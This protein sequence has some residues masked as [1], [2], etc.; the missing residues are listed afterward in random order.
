MSTIKRSF[1]LKDEDLDFISE[2]LR[3]AQADLLRLVTT[4]SGRI[5]PQW[6]ETLRQHAERCADIREQ[7]EGR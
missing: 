4:L 7:I 3:V 5:A 2:M 6:L 1:L